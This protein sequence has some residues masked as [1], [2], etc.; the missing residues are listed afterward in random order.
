MLEYRRYGRGALLMEVPQ[1]VPPNQV[2]A[3]QRTASVLGR[4]GTQNGIG[5]REI[6]VT[7]Y[8]V[9]APT[10]AA[11]IRLSFQRMQ[12]KVSDACGL[13]PQDLGTRSF[14]YDYSN[15]PS[16]N[17]AAPRS[18]TSPPR[19]QIRSTLCAA[20]PRVGSIRSSASGTSGNCGTARIRQPHGGKMGRPP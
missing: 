18:P 9:T 16:W 12:A 1:G 20:A 6:T 3:V 10:L 7:G 2:A 11:P 5:V 8:V 17:L 13:W 4:F 15:Q 14:A 19:S